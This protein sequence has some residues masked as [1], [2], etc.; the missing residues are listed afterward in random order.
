MSESVTPPVKKTSPFVRGVV[1]YGP[2]AFWAAAY[3]AYRFILRDPQP[4]V[5]AT[6]WLVIGSIV[7][8]TLGWFAER[9]IAPLPLLAGLAAV[10]FGT[11]TI[12]FND[13]L[14]VKIKPT[15]INLFFAAALAVGLLL[16]RLFLKDLIGEQ[17]RMTDAA[18]RTLTFRYIGWFLFVAVLNEVVWRTQSESFWVLFRMPGLLIGTVL[19]SLAMLP[20][21]MKHGRFAANEPHT[22]NLPPEG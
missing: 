15:V 3:I 20:F 2:L 18:W 11:L 5:Q 12:A 1:D 17:L 7:A 9:R 6:W 4:L 8:L 14:F 22:P 21:M 19:F 10:V 16:K 13:T